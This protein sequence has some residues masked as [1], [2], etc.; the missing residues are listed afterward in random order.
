MAA[1]PLLSRLRKRAQRELAAAEDILASELF[2][3]FPYAV[4]HGGTSIWRCY[5]SNR[6]SEDID[7]YLPK[8]AV[9][10]TVLE[11][12]Q[13][14]LETRG[15]T[16]KKFRIKHNSIYS[17]FSYLSINIRFEAVFQDKK[18]FV[19]KP[20]E[21]SDGNFLNINTLSPEGLLMEK[22]T[23]YKDRRKM[24]D[25]YDIYFLLRIVNKENLKDPLREFLRVFKEPVDP[26]SLE[27]L[28]FAGVPPSLAEMLEEIKRWAE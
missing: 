15:F 23:T 11:E 10:S 21:L 8:S 26:E 4:L 16:V 6:F 7:V 27:D 2:K 14:S 28:V 9:G 24:R 25:L 22:L 18:T 17:N 1:L 12:F 13:K 5:G 3:I 20:F 19:T